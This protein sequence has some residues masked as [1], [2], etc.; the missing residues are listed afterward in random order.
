MGTRPC[1]CVL[2]KS[3]HPERRVRAFAFPPQQLQR[4]DA[5]SKDLLFAFHHNVYR[6]RIST[7]RS[8]IAFTSPG[9]VYSSAS[10]CTGN[11][12]SRSV[13]D[14]TGPIDAL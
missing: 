5:Q 8:T 2:S 9:M 3:C 12:N 1:A 10:I 4:A 7:A 11:P 6:F 14:V 13:A